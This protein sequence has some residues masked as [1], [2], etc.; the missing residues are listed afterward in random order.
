[1]PKRT[2][3]QK[4]GPAAGLHLLCHVDPRAFAHLGRVPDDAVAVERWGEGTRVYRPACDHYG[5]FASWV[6]AIAT[7]C[8]RE[9]FSRVTLTTF[10][11]G[12]QVAKEVC[13]GSDL[14]DAIVMLDG[15]YADKPRGARQDDGQVL[16]DEGLEAI[17]E[18]AIAAARGER[19]LAILHSRIVTSYASSGECARAI[20]GRV[21][22]AMGAPL[23]PD[24]RALEEELGAFNSAVAMGGLHIVEFPGKDTAEHA[25]EGQ[26]YGAAWRCFLP[27]M[28]G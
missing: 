21:E 18:Y 24:P 3:L 15:L 16:F 12:S 8:D 23:E 28:V 1:M 13:K 11:A 9:G 6:S 26:L 7:E 4:G 10:S 27:W 5:G 22:E 20:R 25:R 2:I 17:A 14:P 19:T